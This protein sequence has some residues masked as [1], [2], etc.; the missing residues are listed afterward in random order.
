MS[1]E[2]VVIV[3]SGASIMPKSIPLDHL[4]EFIE[5]GKMNFQQG[6]LLFGG[7]FLNDAINIAEELLALKERA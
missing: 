7:E 4:K 6:S 2:P 1:D 5:F 3:D